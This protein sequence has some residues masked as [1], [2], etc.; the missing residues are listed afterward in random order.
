MKKTKYL[1]PSTQYTDVELEQGFMKASVFEGGT[2]NAD[3]VT[4]EEHG[5]ATPTKDGQT[6]YWEG[7]Y[8]GDT[9]D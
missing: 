5:F 4:I 9:W 2:E 8:S 3:G 6:N 7:D 1:A